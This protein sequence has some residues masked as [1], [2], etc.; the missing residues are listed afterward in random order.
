M[1]Q[2]QQIARADGPPSD[3]NN[4]HDLPGDNQTQKSRRHFSGAEIVAV[5]RRHLV[6]GEKVSDLCQELDIA[7]NQFYRWQK[8]LFDNGTA[9]FEHRSSI[10]ENARILKLEEQNAFLTT[11]LAKKDAVIAE[12]VEEKARFEQPLTRDTY[13]DFVRFAL[14]SYMLWCLPEV[15]YNAWG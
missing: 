4:G 7:V 8:K 11:K 15:S 2:Q 9:A 3:R 12:A 10:R 6:G 1:E 14:H 13:R 5:L